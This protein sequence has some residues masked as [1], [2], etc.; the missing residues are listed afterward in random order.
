MFSPP[1]PTLENQDDLLLTLSAVSEVYIILFICDT[2]QLKVNVT[3]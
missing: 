2:K 1:N 3:K